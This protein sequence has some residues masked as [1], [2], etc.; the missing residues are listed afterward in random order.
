MALFPLAQSGTR[1]AWRS[2]TSRGTS[3]NCKLVAAF[4]S[5]PTSSEKKK[6]PQ[7]LRQRYIPLNKKETISRSSTLS[8]IGNERI[9]EARFRKAYNPNLAV[10]TSGRLNIYDFSS[11]GCVAM[12]L[13]GYINVSIRSV[14]NHSG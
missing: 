3:R 5:G 10:M 7:I 11:S 1:V 14:V 6:C 8:S 2:P 4:I 13:D 9:F 12:L